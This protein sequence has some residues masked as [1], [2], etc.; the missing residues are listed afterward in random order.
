MLALA[1][2]DGPLGADVHFTHGTCEG[3]I[4]REPRGENG[5][6]Y[7]PYFEPAGYACT[8]AELAAEEK[9]TISHRAKAAIA[10]RDFLARYLTSTRALTRAALRYIESTIG[11]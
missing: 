2:P 6:G 8:M 1:D 3:R 11:A 9:N 5:F 4:R 10:M 7:D